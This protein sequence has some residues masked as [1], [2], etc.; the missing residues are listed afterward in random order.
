MTDE[1]STRNDPRIDRWA[2]YFIK[3]ILGL[4]LTIGAGYAKTTGEKVDAVLA[5]QTKL[6]R[7]QA[8]QGAMLADA[9]SVKRELAILQ[10][11]F[12]KLE[13]KLDALAADRG[14]APR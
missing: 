13:S 2:D 9:V 14:A 8:V 11:Q 12:A 6:E 7:E 1:A 4:I 3:A 5:A 10:I